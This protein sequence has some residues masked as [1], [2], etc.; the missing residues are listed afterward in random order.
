MVAVVIYQA[1]RIATMQFSPISLTVAAIALA[2]MV[3]G[4]F[5][6]REKTD[7]GFSLS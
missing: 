6:K 3:Y 2:L 5:V 4:I 1:S 7:L